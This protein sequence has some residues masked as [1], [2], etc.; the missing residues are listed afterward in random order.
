MGIQT[1]ARAWAPVSV[2]C[3]SGAWTE[4]DLSALDKGELIEIVLSL[5]AYAKEALRLA[6]RIQAEKLGLEME[7]EEERQELSRWRVG[8]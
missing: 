2:V 3:R 8:R 6:G 4:V 7:L 5:D 1:E